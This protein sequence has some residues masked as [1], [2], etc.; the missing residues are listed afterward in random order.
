MIV[1]DEPKRLSNLQDHGLDFE[2]ARDH[3]AFDEAKILPTYPGA[4]GRV[5][6]VAVGDMDGDLVAI[7]FSPLGTEA[8]SLISLRRASR[9]ERKA[10]ASR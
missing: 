6:F 10:Y 2:T 3:F 4:D 7:V 1:W 5:R 8:I 9:K